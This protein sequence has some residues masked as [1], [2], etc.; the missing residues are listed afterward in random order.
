MENN[1]GEMAC[2]LSKKIE[3]LKNEFYTDNKKPVLFKSAAKSQCAS[4]I[5]GELGI[6]N[7]LLHSIFII[8]N[9]NKIFFDYTLFKSY[10]SPENYARIVEFISDKIVSCI[11]AYG[12]YEVHANLDT[13]SVSACQR[14]KDVIQL[15]CNRC[16]SNNSGYSKQLTVMY[17]YNA[18]YMFQQISNMLRPFI[19]YSVMGKIVLCDKAGSPSAIQRLVQNA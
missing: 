2:E 11:S 18:P 8:P 9:T 14:Y 16:I 5:C 13:F 3:A 10:A 12:N 4:A 6:S 7:L 17:I 15:F 19:D 1:T